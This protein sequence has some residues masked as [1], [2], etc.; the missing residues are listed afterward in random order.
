MEPR[1]T[2]R[3]YHKG[4]CHVIK[5]KIAPDQHLVPP[6]IDKKMKASKFPQTS[7][8]KKQHLILS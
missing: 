3:P 6:I 5:I 1:K 8:L 2:E 7:I 4:Y